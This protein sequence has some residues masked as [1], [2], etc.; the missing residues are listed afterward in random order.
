MK[1]LRRSLA[2]ALAL[3]CAQA[4]AQTPSA[5][6][7]AL[8]REGRKLL[9]AGDYAA[10]CAKFADSH[11]LDPQPVTLM[12]LALCNEKR[13]NTATAY[14]KWQEGEVLAR[15]LNDE[16]LQELARTHMA[17]LE[18]QIPHLVIE[19][20]APSA[21]LEI[22]LDGVKLPATALGVAIPVDPGLHL[23]VA[24]A[25]AKREW[26]GSVEVPPGN[27]TVP[28]RVPALAD[29]PLPPPPPPPFVVPFL[30]PPPPF[31][32]A[33]PPSDY[34]WLAGL[35]FGVAAAGLL[36]GA[37]TGGIAAKKASTLKDT[38]RCADGRC[39]PGFEADLPPITTLANVANVTLAVGGAGL[40]A[41]VVGVALQSR[42]DHAMVAPSLGPGWAGV[43]GVF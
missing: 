27:G 9:D 2:L 25:T 34:R 23:A 32:P 28:L 6:A 37:V 5:I 15:H 18:P 29:A 36:V 13:G 39:D 3:V 30:P 41:G 26:H 14:D 11:K 33:P 16:K 38:Y 4:G 35:G 1:R 10:A 8:F 19:L 22:T 12:N 31:R 7:E 20:A 21:G 17:A 43:R 42:R 24:T 40:C